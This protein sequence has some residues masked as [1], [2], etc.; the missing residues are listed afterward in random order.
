MK[1]EHKIKKELIR[2]LEEL[3]KTRGNGDGKNISDGPNTPESQT[4]N[5]IY[6]SFYDYSPLMCN[7][8][9]RA[10]SIV[11]LNPQGSLRKR[12]STPTSLPS[13]GEAAWV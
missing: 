4:Q 9:D 11:S 5:I 3:R 1:D 2:E 8:V 6:K 10:D 13:K 12:Y 7:I